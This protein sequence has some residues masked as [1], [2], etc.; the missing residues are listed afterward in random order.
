MKKKIYKY[1]EQLYLQQIHLAK[2]LCAQ[3]EP[4]MQNK[5]PN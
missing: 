3:N 1:K 2:A 4:K 5:R